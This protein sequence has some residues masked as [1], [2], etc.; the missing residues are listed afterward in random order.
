MFPRGGE[1]AGPDAWVQAGKE[2]DGF[3]NESSWVTLNGAILVENEPDCQGYRRLPGPE[4]GS[5]VL[6]V[7]R[8]WAGCTWSERAGHEQDWL[9]RMRKSQDLGAGLSQ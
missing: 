9:F 3:G 1:R 4:G 7:R 6:Q 2:A 5:N 8:E